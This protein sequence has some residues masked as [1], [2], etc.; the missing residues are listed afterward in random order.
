LEEEHLKKLLEILEKNPQTE[1]ALTLSNQKNIPYAVIKYEKKAFV[2][3]DLETETASL[4][5]D[6][7][8]LLSALQR[9]WNDKKKLAGA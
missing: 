4:H 5:T 6:I 2:L 7:W 3:S 9:Y 1:I 8:T